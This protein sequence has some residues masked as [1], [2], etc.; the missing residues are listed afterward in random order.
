M[1]F[2]RKYKKILKHIRINDYIIKLEKD[3][4]SFFRLIYSLKSVELKTLKIYIG[5]NLTNGFI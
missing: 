5:I 2:N 3:K 4:Q 1:F